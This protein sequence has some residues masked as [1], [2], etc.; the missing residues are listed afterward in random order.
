MLLSPLPPQDLADMARINN[1]LR[2]K[3]EKAM[4]QLIAAQTAKEHARE[5]VGQASAHAQTHL[6]TYAHTQCLAV[7]PLTDRQQP[8][9]RRRAVQQ[10]LSD[11]LLWRPQRARVLSWCGPTLLLLP[12]AAVTCCCRCLLSQ[13]HE[14]SSK[15]VQ[16]YSE[17]QQMGT[18]RAQLL[19]ERQ[20]ML[21]AAEK[22]ASDWQALKAKYIQK[23]ST[24]KEVGCAGGFVSGVGVC[25]EGGQ[26]EGLFV[27]CQWLPLPVW[28]WRSRGPQA[29]GRHA[30][31]RACGQVTGPRN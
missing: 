9:Q 2:G 24:L 19:T 12:L 20:Q 17:C 30:Q 28:V 26:F 27:A 29:Q 21:A 22:R 7:W 11:R 31:H 15:A 1:E 18:E 3:L 23:S 8:Q 16:Y 6:H 4:E 10:E 14:E 13:A 25:V 5:K